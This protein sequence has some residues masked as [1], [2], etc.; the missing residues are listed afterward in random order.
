MRPR[1]CGQGSRSRSSSS[2]GCGRLCEHVRQVPGS[3]R[4]SVEGAYLPF[5]RQSGGHSNDA[6]ETGYGCLQ[7]QFSY[8]VVSLPGVVLRLALLVQRVQ[9]NLWSSHR[10]SFLDKVVF[11]RG[12]VPDRPPCRFHWCSSWRRRS[13]S[14][15]SWCKFRSPWSQAVSADHGD[16]PRCS[17]LMR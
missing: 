3:R 13:S 5:L 6:T 1:R 9:K 15:L 8:K 7:V 11:L 14:S 4:S 10:C 16:F 17:T 12:I 2:G